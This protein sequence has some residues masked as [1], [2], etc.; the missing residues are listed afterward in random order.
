MTKTAP[1]RYSRLEQAIRRIR[2][3]VDPVPRSP[4]T[5]G[6]LPEGGIASINLVPPEKLISFFDRCISEL[7]SLKGPEIGDYMEFGIFNG[8]ALGSMYIAREEADAADAFRIFGFDA[9]EG[10]EQG[11]EEQDVGVFVSGDYKCPRSVTEECL[12]DH[13]VNLEKIHLVEGWFDETLTPSLSEDFGLS[14]PGIIFIDCDTYSA[15]KTVLDF[16]APQIK[17][18]AIICLDDWKL[19]DLDL[20]GEG[21]YRAFN[22]FLEE[23]PDLRAARIPSYNRKSESFI[24]QPVGWHPPAQDAL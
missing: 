3:T 7:Q 24:V 11:V 14:S 1:F 9:F 23:N 20:A 4:W 21:E 17:A 10:L 15:S 19:N 13:G 16:I 6:D 12:Q 2:R 8:N 18:P 5:Q 22:E